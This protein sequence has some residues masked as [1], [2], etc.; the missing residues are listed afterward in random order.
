[1]PENAKHKQ[2]RA[3]KTELHPSGSS[4]KKDNKKKAYPY[5]DTL[6]FANSEIKIRK[7]QQKRSAKNSTF[8]PVLV[9]F[10]KIEIGI[11]YVSVA[12]LPLFFV[13]MMSTARLV[14]GGIRRIFR[15][16]V[17]DFEAQQPSSSSPL[18]TDQS[19]I[20]R[21]KGARRFQHFIRSNFLSGCPIQ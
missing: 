12:A 9:K 13:R 16:A 14:R 2:R 10:K 21:C 11:S 6:C 19:R 3:E 17:P 4:S 1:M 15:Y 20:C 8:R 18:V 7:A 5:K